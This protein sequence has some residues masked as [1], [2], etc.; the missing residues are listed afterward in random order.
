MNVYAIRHGLTELNKRHLING[1]LEDGLAPE[2]IKEAKEAEPF[3]PKSVK[4]IYSSPLLRA[5]ETA[6]ILNSNLKAQLSFHDELKEVDFGLLNGT[7]FTDEVRTKHRSLQY[8]WR[9][10]GGESFENV[11]YRLLKILGEIKKT[12]KDGEALIVTH[13]GI[14]RLLSFLQDGALMGKIENASFYS[15]DLD[16]IFGLPEFF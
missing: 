10:Q 1:H 15:F 3:V 4:R 2:G 12:N 9:S 16:K 13:G 5:K 14:I 7:D 6:L 11:K 8:D